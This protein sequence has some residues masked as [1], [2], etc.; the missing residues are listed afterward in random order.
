MKLIS[1]WLEGSRNYHIGAVLYKHFGTD[2]K[3]KALFQTSPDKFKHDR[4]IKELVSI[5]GKHP[6]AILAMA[7]ADPDQI[8]KSNDPILEAIRNEWLPIY[9]RMQYLRHELDRFKGA[10]KKAIEQRHHIAKEILAL[11]QTCMSI[12]AK[13]DHYLE[14]GKLPVETKEKPLPMDPAELG[15][16]IES[17][18]RNI[19]RNQLLAK[20]YPDNTVY[21]SKLIHYQQQLKRIEDA[22]KKN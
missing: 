16:L 12:W 22:N 15:R 5:Y 10:S 14:S 2:A 9:Q 4:L 8:Q 19:R 1:K 21:A 3:L 7:N 6:A 13:R 20:K 11:E 18:K 17:T